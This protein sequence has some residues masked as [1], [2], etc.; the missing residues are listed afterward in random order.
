MLSNIIRHIP[1]AASTV[2]DTP[3]ISSLLLLHLKIDAAAST[4]TVALAT[5]SLHL[6]AALALTSDGYAVSAGQPLVAPA[7]CAL[8]AKHYGVTAATAHATQLHRAAAACLAALT[9]RGKTSRKA[10]AGDAGACVLVLECLIMYGKSISS[11]IAISTKVIPEDW[12]DGAKYTARCA[13][14]TA[15]AAAAAACTIT[16]SLLAALSNLS[17]LDESR[18]CLGYDSQ[19]LSIERLWRAL[20]VCMQVFIGGSRGAYFTNCV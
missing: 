9:T 2:C 1:S 10:L 15:A 4:P 7:A 6:L 5:A 3:D 13:A 16:S 19:T 14:S 17:Q 12:N 20:I 18:S 11:N 8:L